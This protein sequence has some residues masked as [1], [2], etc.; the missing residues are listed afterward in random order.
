MLKVKLVGLALL[1]LSIGFSSCGKKGSGNNGG[2]GG[3]G[4]SGSTVEVPISRSDTTSLP[5]SIAPL[6]FS[7]DLS[8]TPL[9]IDTFATKVDEYITPYGFKKSDITKVEVTSLNIV[10]ENSPGQTFNFI[11]DT[12]TSIRVYVDSFNGSAP[13]QVAFKQSIT[14][15]STSI[16][17]NV[18]P[19]DIKNYFNAD[20]MKLLV[21]FRTQENEGLNAATKFRVNYG[22]KVTAIMP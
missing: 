20:Y 10:L 22:F 21:G 7:I 16:T 4:N 14:P 15:G 1:I 11:K 6:P 12:L 19:V 5:T 18:D 2:G 9:Q 13:L 17:L 8:T 3:G